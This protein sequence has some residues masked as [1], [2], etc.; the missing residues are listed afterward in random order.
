M[1]LA[2]AAAQAQSRDGNLIEYG[3]GGFAD[4]G[5]GPPMLFPPEVKIYR[6]GRIVFAQKEGVWEGRLEPK[7]LQ[8]LERELAKNTLLQKSQ[9]LPVRNGGLISMHGGIAYIRY[10]DGEDE[11]IVAVLSHPHRGPYVRLLNT[12]RDEIPSTYRRFRPEELSF[13]LYPGSSWQT[14][15]RWPFSATLPLRE[16]VPI[17]TTDREAVA[18]ILDRAFG[19][20]S[21]LQTNVTEAGCDYEIIVESVPDWY[22]PGVLAMTLEML[23]LSSN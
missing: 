1:L 21:W 7:R 13:R 14:P 2:A 22:E 11:V 16:G 20:F 10:R 6:D 15:V 3:M 4:G 18:F 19:G 12:I 17:T 8:R 5:W 9:L 23:R